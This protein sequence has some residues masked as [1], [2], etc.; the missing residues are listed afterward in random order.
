VCAIVVALGA[1]AEPR[2]AGTV[3]VAFSLE[4]CFSC[5]CSSSRSGC[6][7]VRPGDVTVLPLRRLCA[8]RPAT[9]ASADRG[10]GAGA[11]PR[12]LVESGLRCEAPGERF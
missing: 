6:G 5:T 4:A 11:S 1:L 12:P 2:V 3:P 7:T 10:H 9:A 8:H